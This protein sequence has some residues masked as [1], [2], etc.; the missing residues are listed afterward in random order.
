MILKIVNVILLTAGCILA[1]LGVFGRFE[2]LHLL[3]GFCFFLIFVF[4][5]L[6]ADKK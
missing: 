5:D 3:G 6:F 1:L 4:T 2:G